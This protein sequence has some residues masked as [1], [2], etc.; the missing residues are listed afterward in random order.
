MKQPV[1]TILVTAA[2]VAGL[3]G[4][5]A[6]PVAAQTRMSLVTIPESIPAVR[7]DGSIST[8]DRPGFRVEVLRAA[9]KS[10]NATVSFVPAPWQRAMEL[11]KSGTVDGA[12]SASWSEER[13]TFGAFPVKN[14]TP[15][16]AKAMKGYSYSLFVHPDSKLRWDGKAVTGSERKVIVERGSAGIALATRLGLEP[17]EA[18]GYANMVRMLVEKR[19]QGL[20]AVDVHV[21]RV[22]ADDPRLGS[23]VKELQPALEAKHGYVMFGKPYYQ[24][25][26][27][28]VE[29]FWKSLAEI[30]AKPAYKELVRSYNNGEFVE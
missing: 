7:P 18:S 11:V 24:A 15:D 8:P 4:L 27:A 10:C 29:C 6:S 25:N 3:S 16:P 22:L 5:F 13:E 14:G 21:D 1:S 23:S 19:A 12:F 26:K 17:V 2:A 28:L 30:R 9:G 20:V